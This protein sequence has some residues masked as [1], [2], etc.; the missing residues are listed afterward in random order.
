[1]E[2]F[3]IKNFYLSMKEILILNM[4]QIIF[5]KTADIS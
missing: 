1:M 5:N 2:F 3:E 4:S